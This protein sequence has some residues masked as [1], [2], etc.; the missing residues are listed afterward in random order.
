[1][2]V[3]ASE[4]SISFPKDR[5]T[6]RVREAAA[7][8]GQVLET[9]LPKGDKTFVIRNHRTMAMWLMSR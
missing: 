1:M 9:E 4:P 5:T 7:L 2:I 3:I 6:K 8:F